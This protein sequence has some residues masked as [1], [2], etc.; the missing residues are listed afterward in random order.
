M[1]RGVTQERDI[2][3]V[4][5]AASAALEDERE[6][7]L[8]RAFRFFRDNPDEMLTRPD[9]QVKFGCG[10]EHA[11][12]I[13]RRLIQEGVP[14]AQLPRSPRPSQAK[15]VPK[16][17]SVFPDNLEPK[18]RRVLLAFIETQGTVR[19][20]AAAAGVAFHTAET[21]LRDARRKAGVN[22]TAALVDLYRAATQRS[23]A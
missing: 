19:E 6:T 22:T 18:Q 9:I 7:A 11:K 3:S 13:A 20:A 23:A 14:R 10:Y 1:S 17:P 5:I 15:A 12:H 4:T 21:Y 16:P 8:A 2:R